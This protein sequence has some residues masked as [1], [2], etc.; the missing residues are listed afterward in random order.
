MFN[1]LTKN[2][3]M[4]NFYKVMLAFVLYMSATAFG[5]AQTC[6]S[7]ALSSL[8]ENFDSL[9][10]S[11]PYSWYSVDSNNH[12]NLDCW[13]VVNS[14]QN[15][16][17]AYVR[18]YSYSSTF[19]P[20]TVNPPYVRMYNS[21]GFMGDLA[22]VTPRMDITNYDKRVKFNAGMYYLNDASSLIVG[23]VDSADANSGTSG[24]TSF[25]PIDTFGFNG[26]NNLNSFE[27]RLDSLSGYNGTDEY[28]AFKMLIAGTYEYLIID[29]VVIEDIPA[30][31]AVMSL[32][33]TNVLDTSLDV[34]WT[35]NAS[36]HLVEYGPVGFT[37]ASGTMTVASNMASITGLA[38]NTTYDVKITPICAGSPGEDSRIAVTTDCPSSFSGLS[39]DFELALAGG[40]TNPS[41][42][43]CWSYYKSG[44]YAY[45]VYGY[46]YNSTTYAN[47][48]SKSFRLYASSSSSY[49]DTAMLAS[50]VIDN[51][52]QSR[53]TFS[54]RTFYSSTFY[55]SELLVGT[56]DDQAT[57]GSFV[58][59]DTI[60]LPG[61]TSTVHQSFTVEFNVSTTPTSGRVAFA[62]SN[63]GSTQYV[64]LDDIVIDLIPQCNDIAMLSASGIT[65]VSAVVSWLSDSTSSTNYI[66][67]GPSGFTQGT[68]TVLTTTSDSVTITN[69]M[70]G[71]IYDVYVYSECGIFTSTTAGPLTFNTNICDT[72]DL[73]S[74]EFHALD[75]YG[76]GWNGNAVEVVDA[77]TGIVLASISPTTGSNT[78]YTVPFCD[79]TDIK[80]VYSN[81]GSYTYECGFTLVF[82]GDTIASIAT[83][84][85]NNGGFYGIPLDTALYDGKLR[86]RYTCVRV[87]SMGASAVVYDGLSLAFSGDT[88]TSSYSIEYGPVGFGQGTGVVLPVA[89][90][91][92]TMSGLPQFE[93]TSQH[94]YVL[95]SCYS[96][97]GPLEV[98][99]PCRTTTGTINASRDSSK[100]SIDYDFTLQV[101]ATPGSTV[102]WNFGNGTFAFGDSV[103]AI[104]SNSTAS[105]VV[106]AEITNPCGDAV[107][108]FDTV[109]VTY[110]ALNID[111]LNSS[112]MIY[113]NPSTGKVTIGGA[114][115]GST[116]QVRDITG[117]LVLTKSFDI[118]TNIDLSMMSKG[119]YLVRVNETIK[120]LIIE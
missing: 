70:S 73:C 113:P 31:P 4:K 72:S 63:N 91:T 81:V 22:L 49:S 82:S 3:F 96:A 9:N 40:S 75:S 78:M 46:T 100:L 23:T 84:T 2:C 48:G 64:A 114:S 59:L 95:D 25:N 61:A 8:S 116:L 117:K 19:Y 86:C 66:E 112:L 33:I 103:K 35:S 1:C 60:A 74:L 27:V 28:I 88:S 92:P 53:A 111:E 16:T 20:A 85:Y 102:V 62:V 21:S 12:N 69:L 39:E 80:F 55:N 13:K 97:F 37:Q 5:N 105:Y 67:Y 34:S 77:N 15:T 6:D 115:N 65:D 90:V 43:A 11:P 83:G 50:P 45:S 109:E 107:T 38:A 120:R 26:L 57:P 51:L 42:P 58:I 54:A 47:S 36:S 52:H 24:F 94:F 93:N 104:F 110:S 7:T 44:T 10:V 14:I 108:I 76:D 118:Q 18:G 17:S 119:L 106:S 71:T 79:R 29:D 98:D 56:L 87:D 68:G 41:Q 101:D 30:C 89:S 99:F 32:A